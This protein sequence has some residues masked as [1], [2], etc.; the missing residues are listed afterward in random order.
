M[1]C[2]EGPEFIA[3]QCC[4]PGP[5][6]WD[7]R[8]IHTFIEHSVSC[9]KNLP[10]CS[11]SSPNIQALLYI[12]GSLP[13]AYSSL[14]T[15]SSAPHLWTNCHLREK[16]QDS[17]KTLSS[18]ICSLWFLQSLLAF[19]IFSHIH[20]KKRKPHNMPFFVDAVILCWINSWAYSFISS[21]SINR[22]LTFVRC[23]PRPSRMRDNRHSQ[24][25][26]AV[27]KVTR[28]QRSNPTRLHR[29][30]VQQGNGGRAMGNL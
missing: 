2:C 19:L 9:F 25:L 18:W 15:V 23:C 13:S 1:G 14:Y 7:T 8:L 4:L 28:G 22:A 21:I 24:D 30:S 27:C 26:Q 17:S 10:P 12:P 6:K 3:L 29:D 16:L 5:L 20:E 11:A